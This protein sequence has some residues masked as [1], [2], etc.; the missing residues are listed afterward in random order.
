MQSTGLNYPAIICKNIEESVGFY[1][2]LGMEQ[3]YME[4]N[5]DD[6]ES[7]QTLLHAGGDTFLLLVGPTSEQVKIAESS[8]GV[9]SMQYLSLTIS[10]GAMDRIYV[11]MSNSGVRG[12]EEIRRG[13]ER[14]VF[15]EDPNGVLVTLTAWTTE[16]PAGVSRAAVLAQAAALREQEGA[17]FIE[18]THLQRAVAALSSG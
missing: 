3:L 13:Y 14:L 12:S 6:P 18:D 2:R 8:L 5:R 4:A 11:E 9:G 1:Q 10:A 7:V 15:L 16:P 17:P